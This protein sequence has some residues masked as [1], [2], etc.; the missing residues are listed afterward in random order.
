[1]R[2]FVYKNL[3][4]D[5]WSVM[6][7][8]T[9]LVVDHCQTISLENAIFKVSDKGRERVRNEKR[10]NVHAGVLGH[11][12][13]NPKDNISLTNKVSYNPYI[14]ERFVIKKWDTE[15]EEAEMVYLN[16][17]EVFV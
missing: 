4:K 14:N 13:K 11:R 10:K 16:K 12:T 9:K 8:K 2:V 17:G 5:C 7:W 15:I 3:H 1:M 6:N